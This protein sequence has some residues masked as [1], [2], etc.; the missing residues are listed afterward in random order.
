MLLSVVRVYQ[1]GRRLSGCE[2][3]TA[4]GIVGDVRIHVERS[5]D[6][7]SIR[8]AICMD[9]YKEACLPSSSRS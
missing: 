5:I 9:G 8:K 4:V 7:R 6:G 1:Q 3:R 2:L